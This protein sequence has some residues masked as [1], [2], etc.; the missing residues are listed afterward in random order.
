[1]G[2]LSRFGKST[3]PDVRQMSQQGSIKTGVGAETDRRLRQMRFSRVLERY[4]DVILTLKS[5]PSGLEDEA[6]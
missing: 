2:A 1:M 6:T 3:P 5:K 4:D